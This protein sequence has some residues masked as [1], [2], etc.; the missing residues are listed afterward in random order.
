MDATDTK[1]RKIVLLGSVVVFVTTAGGGGRAFSPFPLPWQECV[2]CVR[3]MMVPLMFFKCIFARILISSTVTLGDFT[4]K[5]IHF[6]LI[7]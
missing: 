2:R 4:N 3:G 7:H 1:T 6:I 5:M